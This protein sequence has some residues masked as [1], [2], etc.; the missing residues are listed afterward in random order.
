MWTPSQPAVATLKWLDNFTPATA[1]LQS[2]LGPPPSL[3]VMMIMHS[4]SAGASVGE[5]CREASESRPRRLDTPTKMKQKMKG[6]A[7]FFLNGYFVLIFEAPIRAQG[8]RCVFSCFHFVLFVIRGLMGIYSINFTL[9][10]ELGKS[11][12][13]DIRLRCQ[14]VALKILHIALFLP[15]PLQHLSH[16]LFFSPSF[17]SFLLFTVL[18]QEHTA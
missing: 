10:W 14:G 3:R 4:S 15:S 2:N 7:V 5:L 13:S 9:T 17:P 11:L 18:S 16:P 12:P 6:K 8:K 1:I